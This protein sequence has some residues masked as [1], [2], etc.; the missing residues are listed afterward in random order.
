MAAQTPRQRLHA[1]INSKTLV[2]APGVYDGLTGRLAANAGFDVA[3]MTGAGTSIRKGYPDYGLLTM[4][5]MV[6]NASDITAIDGLAVIADAD[7]GYGNEL[8]MTRTVHE[9]E[10]AGVAAIHIEDQG[11]PKRCGHLD[12]K[13]IIPLEDYIAKIRAAVAA[14]TDPDFQIIARTDSRAVMGLEEAIRRANAS[15]EAGAD[16]AFV[17]APQ[18]PDEV[19]AVPK[20]VKGPCLFNLVYGGKTPAFELAEIEAMG[21][22]LAILPDVLLRS[23]MMTCEG[24][25]E[26]LKGNGT[27]PDQSKGMV[28]REMFER[29]GSADWDVI[30]TA[31]AEPKAEAAE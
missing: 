1:Q 15:L 5:E 6:D 16:I 18:T 22:A 25:L 24:I 30:R 29:M 8:N 26:P 28:V 14:R 20:A 2:V 19:R 21:F 9:Y 4:T 17:E 13:E 23:V 31:Y 12:D 10:R 11:F 3:Y 27:L 7:T